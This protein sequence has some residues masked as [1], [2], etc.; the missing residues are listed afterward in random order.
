MGGWP[1]APTIARPTG[2]SE[3]VPTSGKGFCCRSHSKVRKMGGGHRIRPLLVAYV[4]C[5]PTLTGQPIT[6]GWIPSIFNSGKGWG[7]D[8]RVALLCFEEQS[9]VVHLLVSVLSLP[10]VFGVLLDLCMRLIKGSTGFSMLSHP[11][12]DARVAP[13]PPRG[14]EAVLVGA[15]RVQLWVSGQA[16]A[17]RLTELPP[18]AT[19][20]RGA[21]VLG[22]GCTRSH[23]LWVLGLRSW[24]HRVSSLLTL[25]GSA[26]PADRPWMG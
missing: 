11:L 14:P 5:S 21:P 24:P 19:S 7:S 10:F 18:K 13:P 16:H 22:V 4:V 1:L 2:F 6:G 26:P 9:S 3:L 23:P 25:S 20:S 12:Q 8:D 17:Q 15:R